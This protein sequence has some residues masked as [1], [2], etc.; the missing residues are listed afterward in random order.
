MFD[1]MINEFQVLHLHD[2]IC[3]DGNRSFR[4]KSGVF[5]IIRP[6]KSWL[7]F[8]WVSYQHFWASMS[9]CI[10]MIYCTY[11][12]HPLDS[13]FYGVRFSHTRLSSKPTVVSRTWKV[14]DAHLD[15][16][17]IEYFTHHKNLTLWPLVRDD[18]L[19][20]PLLN[21]ISLEMFMCLLA[22]FFIF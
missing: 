3:A 10:T 16:V 7:E 21:F 2:V 20:F 6:V 22:S 8:P 13:N 9:Y 1:F 14:R 17:N 19:F 11:P 12:H 5:E 15:A 18:W 4:E